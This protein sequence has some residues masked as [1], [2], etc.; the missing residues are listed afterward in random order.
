MLVHLHL[1]VSHSQL[2]NDSAWQFSLLRRGVAF[3]TTVAQARSLESPVRRRH[4]GL[5]LCSPRRMRLWRMQSQTTEQVNSDP[6]APT[7][8]PSPSAP[9]PALQAVLCPSAHYVSSSSHKDRGVWLLPT[10]A[11]SDREKGTS[12][13]FL[14]IPIKNRERTGWGGEKGRYSEVLPIIQPAPRQFMPTLRNTQVAQS[15]THLNLLMLKNKK[16]TP[17]FW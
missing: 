3:P 7:S 15:L 4:S 16:Q 5:D 12:S 13:C 8:L 6:T 11:G 14:S 10:P 1:K 2:Q 17:M 9:A